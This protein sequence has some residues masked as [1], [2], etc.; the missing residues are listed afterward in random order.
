MIDI[1][2]GKFFV[3][4]G[5]AFSG[6]LFSFFPAHRSN[7]S[8]VYGVLHHLGMTISYKTVSAKVTKSDLL[9]VFRLKE[10]L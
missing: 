5:I 3:V 10:K 8:G 1:E 7:C 4:S 2:W 9:V 6:Q